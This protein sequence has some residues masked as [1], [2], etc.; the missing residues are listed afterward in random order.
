LALALGDQGWNVTGDDVDSRVLDAALARGIVTGTEMTDEHVLVFVATPAGAVSDIV[1]AVLER[2]AS[3]SLLVSDVAG[4]KTTIVRDV[5]DQRFIGGHPMAG[6]ELR[7]IKGAKA[8]LFQGCTWVLTPTDAT[9]PETY[10]VLHG[11]LREIGANVVAVSAEDH[12]RLVAIASHVPHLLAGAL[13]NEAAKAAEQDAVLLQLAAGGFRDMTR[14]AAGDPSIWPDVL[15][16]NREAIAS[17][18]IALE[19]RL[20]NLR[21]A[22]GEQRR[23]ILEESLESASN[24]RRRLPGRALSSDDLSYVRV[25]VSDQPG[26]L[27]SV[28]RAASER[29]VNIYDIEIAH[30]IEGAG[31]T[32]LLAV[33]ASQ[34]DAFCDSLSVLGFQ[35]VKER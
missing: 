16:E 13:M 27:A 8:D 17:T 24:A 1:N 28:T 20:E 2:F 4:V 30:G 26:V 15:V 12:D 25:S 19:K 33:D 10:S 11:I 9:K 3:T 14:V 34:S 23:D 35:V 21:I 18:L 29:L 5:L 6:S 31:G 22:L 32:L 7:G